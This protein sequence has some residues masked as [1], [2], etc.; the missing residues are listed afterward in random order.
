MQVRLPAVA[1]TFY[2]ADAATLA[3]DVERF[4]AEATPAAR[5][6]GPPK[7][8]VAPHAGYIYS[9]PVAGSAYAPL[10]AR[11][12]QLRR[13][14]LLG[15]AHFVPVRGIAA[16]SAAAFRTPLGDA[17][18]DQQ[19]RDALLA[20]GLIVRADHAHTSEHSLEVQLPFLQVL[21]PGVPV[22]PLAVGDVLPAQV[23]QLLDRVWD[24]E[25]T[26]IVVSSD[27]SHYL[28]YH[29]A[30]DHDRRTAA[31]IEAL[32][33]T[34]LDEE[35]A[36]GRIPVAGLL[37]AARRHGLHARGVDLRSSGDTAGPEDRVVGYGAFLFGP[38]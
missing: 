6:S 32:D 22:L 14:V 19:A 11:A 33:A 16:S 13:V 37:L 17:P 7:A 25:E 12:G 23:A 10:R 28:E 35:S 5:A 1:G 38:P 21:L 27:L 2:P 20:E 9:G 15:P 31:A 4:V 3:A 18:V 30:K 36:C 26:A 34:G 8:I 29:E 24:G